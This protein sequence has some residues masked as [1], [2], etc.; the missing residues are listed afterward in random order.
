MKTFIV[1]HLKNAQRPAAK[2][3]RTALKAARL[4]TGSRLVGRKKIR[5]MLV[6][7]QGMKTTAI[8]ART[9]NT[10]N[11]KKTTSEEEE[12]QLRP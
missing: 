4:P 9:P 3:T 10:T 11:A 7:V 12:Q 8:A 1:R 6:A 5:A 2:K